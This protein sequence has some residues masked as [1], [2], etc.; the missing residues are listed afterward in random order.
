MKTESDT[1]C[2][3]ELAL[4]PFPGI[5]YVVILGIGRLCEDYFQFFDFGKLVTQFIERKKREA[6]CRNADF[7]PSSQFGFEVIAEQ[8]QFIVDDFVCHSTALPP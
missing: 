6:R 5:G 8:V 3:K 4:F 1:K 2:Y 7:A